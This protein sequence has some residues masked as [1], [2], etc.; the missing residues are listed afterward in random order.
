MDVRIL[1]NPDNRSTVARTTRAALRPA[2]TAWRTVGVVRNALFDAGIF[3]SYP[4]GIATVSIGNISTGGTGKTPMVVEIVQRLQEAGHH[5]AVL[6]RGYGPHDGTSD[7]HQ[8]F[9][10]TL[11][12]DVPV[13]ANPDRRTGAAKIL[14]AWPETSVFVLDDGFQH[15]CVHR[16]LDLVLVDASAPLQNGRVLPAGLLREGPASL[17]RADAVI[18]THAEQVPPPAIDGLSRFIEARSGHPPLAHASHTWRELL[19]SEGPPFPTS[20]LAHR[21][22]FGACGIGNPNAFEAMLRQHAGRLLDVRSFPDHHRFDHETVQEVL[23]TAHGMGA[24]TVVVTEKDWMKW[25]PLVPN[26]VLHGLGLVRPKLAITFNEGGRALNDLL[27][28]HLPAPEN[29]HGPG[30]PD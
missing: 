15:R 8:L 18:L 19:P 22:V 5:P 7:E 12:T 27:H 6:H 2:A 26:L 28:R 16:D 13:V 29:T 14:R 11:G 23:D 21:A 17:R 24:D 1:L 9:E 4:L 3:R 30:R 10:S 20:D 25:R